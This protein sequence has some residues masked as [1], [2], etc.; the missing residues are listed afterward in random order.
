[1]F[2]DAASERRHSQNTEEHS[3]DLYAC[4]ALCVTQTG[5]N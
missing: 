5:F 2:E 4:I 1:M 3:A